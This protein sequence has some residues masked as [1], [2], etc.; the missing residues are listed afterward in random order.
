MGRADISTARSSR[1]PSASPGVA[2]VAATPTS[3]AD[4][5]ASDLAGVPEQSLNNCVNEGSCVNAS[6]VAPSPGGKKTLDFCDSVACSKGVRRV[7][8]GF[9]R[10]SKG[11]QR[12]LKGIRRTFQ[13]LSKENILI[14]L[15]KP[16]RTF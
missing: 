5:P 15:R 1:V 2:D 8:K 6:M 12:V 11:V 13:G 10:V 4:L 16:F 9:R 14:T 7:S 3:L